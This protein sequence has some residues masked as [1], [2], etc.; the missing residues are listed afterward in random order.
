MP[1]SAL[2]SRL[3]RVLIPIELILKVLSIAAILGGAIWFWETRARDV[4]LGMGHEVF[5]TSL[6][7]GGEHQHLAVIFVLLENLGEKP[8]RIA[9]MTARVQVV[10]PPHPPALDL[11]AADRAT[12]EEHPSFSWP[13]LTEKTDSVGR[14]LMPGESD[15]YEFNFL[16][17]ARFRVIRFYSY[18]PKTP[19]RETTWQKASYHELENLPHP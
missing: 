2:S 9:S 4:H 19:G 3:E 10:D 13:L 16:I 15:L 7:T 18:V 14:Y 5:S 6:A 17:P 11:L 8:I 12:R 1:P